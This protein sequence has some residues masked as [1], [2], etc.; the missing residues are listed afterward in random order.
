MTEHYKLNL[1]D[2]NLDSFDVNIGF[3]EDPTLT[4]KH[5]DIYYAYNSSAHFI[6][7]KNYSP[8]IIATGIAMFYASQLSHL[9]EKAESS[10][11]SH[12]IYT[13]Y[14]LVFIMIAKIKIIPQSDKKEQLERFMNTFWSFYEV[15]F[16]NTGSTLDQQK[17]DQLKTKLAEESTI[18]FSLLAINKRLNQYFQVTN[19]SQTELISWLLA[20]DLQHKTHEKAVKPYLEI[21]HEL[22]QTTSFNALEKRIIDLIVPADV[23]IRYL[24]AEEESIIIAK[25]VLTRIFPPQEY[26]SMLESFIHNEEQTSNLLEACINF[27][28][29][30]NNFFFGLQDYI[31][32]K[33]HEL[34]NGRWTATTIWGTEQFEESLDEFLSHL[35]EDDQIDTSSLPKSIQV[36]TITF[37]KLINFY[38]SLIGGFWIARG[39]NGALRVHKNQLLQN[40]LWLY[41]LFGERHHTI[42][43]YAQ[44]FRLYEKNVF[45][46]QYAFN[47]IRAGKES[48][49]LPS[50]GS[51]ISHESNLF[52]LQLLNESHW[53]I[54]L[55][56]IN[57]C[58]IKLFIKKSE[59]L[60][61]FKDLF[62]DHISANLKWDHHQIIENI[63][64]DYKALVNNKDILSLLQSHL[65][66]QDTMHLKDRMYCLD[67]W[68]YKD[69]IHALITDDIHAE[70]DEALFIALCA[71]A[72]ETLFGFLL[73]MQ[74]ILSCQ[75][76]HQK[77]YESDVL[78]DLYCRKVLHSTDKTH[79]RIY[80]HLVTLLQRYEDILSLWTLLDDNQDY[81]YIGFN[82]RNH[83]CEQ[84]K[85]HTISDENLVWFMS[86]L[87]H[88]TYYNKRFLIPNH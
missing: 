31:K 47:H 55:Q 61:V 45:Y 49:M 1:F 79:D 80:K 2:I 88:I 41:P 85:H 62:G 4:V 44:F 29:I 15:L 76:S 24:F 38:I 65:N 81:M 70:Y 63:Y 6:G 12:F 21:H 51:I 67:F 35:A 43:Y 34:T 48:F 53:A 28:L 56:D 10:Y 30:K 18:F 46:Y 36:Q 33:I 39:D 14:F 86:Y 77:S 17:L 42:Q 58:E 84:H 57:P 82:N 64:G 13:I 5:M 75:E 32:A 83:R 66:E 22:C 19:G 9:F 60:T 37:D 7:Y 40:L 25:H 26:E 11:F 71:Q 8:S 23:L 54:L 3:G 52:I 72:K 69:Y 74:Y 50:Q 87:K 78:I 68:L 27:S 59:I 73:Y 16:E 20:G